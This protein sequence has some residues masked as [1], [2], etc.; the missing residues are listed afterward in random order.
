MLSILVPGIRNYLWNDLYT[1]FEQSLQDEVFE[2]IFV[3]PNPPLSLDKGNVKY[4]CDYGNMIR[5]QQ[6]ALLSAR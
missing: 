5:C 4:V 2:I 1:N 6:V 3:G